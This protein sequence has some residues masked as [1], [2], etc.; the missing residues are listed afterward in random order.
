M[1]GEQLQGQVIDFHSTNDPPGGWA[2][3]LRGAVLADLAWSREERVVRIEALEEVW[4]G[5]FSRG[6][7]FGGVIEAAGGSPQLLYGG[8][9]A[10]GVAASR[11][12]ADYE[13]FAALDWRH[14]AWAGIDDAGGSAVLR[15]R[16]GLGRRGPAFEVELSPEPR[17]RQD[18]WPLVFLWGSLRILRL[19]R[20]FGGILPV[21][22]SRRAAERALGRILESLS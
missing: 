13:L 14:G 21:R 15:A 5:R 6:R 10:T 11:G 18:L 16:G 7:V 2:F 3:T 20:P 8:G 17:H 22:T 9:L 1:F 4:W 19:R 12:G